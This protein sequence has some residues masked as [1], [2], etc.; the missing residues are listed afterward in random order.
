[1]KTQLE[2]VSQLKCFTAKLQTQ[3]FHCYNINCN[4]YSLLLVVVF[5]IRN[6]ILKCEITDVEVFCFMQ[7]TKI[8]I[9]NLPAYTMRVPFTIFCIM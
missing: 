8:I 4:I 1:M 2:T 7:I 9:P 5:K 6:I 3:L